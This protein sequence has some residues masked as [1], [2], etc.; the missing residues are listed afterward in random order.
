M[1]LVTLKDF[2]LATVY[3]TDF[4]KAQQ[5]YRETLGMKLI[6]KMGDGVLLRATEDL[7]I[8]LEGGRKDRAADPLHGTSTSLCFW[9]EGGVKAAS[10]RFKAAGM[11]LVGKYDEFGPDFHMFRIADPCGNVIEFAGK[12]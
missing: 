3:V 12:P 9:P 5:F 6:K 11:V 8:Y 4:E 2:N 1:S 10:E 7:S